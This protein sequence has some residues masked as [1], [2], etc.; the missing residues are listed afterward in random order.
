MK[1]C[2]ST[3]GCH[4]LV[5]DRI[6]DLANKYGIE[7]IEV[8]GINN[9]LDNEKIDDFKLHNAQLTMEKFKSHNVDLYSLGTSCSFHDPNTRKQ[10]IEKGF[11]E[12]HIANSLNVTNIRVFGN[13]ILDS[14]EIS[15]NLV[16]DGLK[17]MCEYALPYD[18]TVLL[19]VH[20]D[21]NSIDTLTPIVNSLKEYTNFGLIW[22]IYHTHSTHKND[23]DKFYDTFKGYIK[24]IHIKDSIGNK[25]VLPGDGEIEFTKIVNYVLN[26]GYDGYFSLEWERKWNPEL[27][28]LE[29]A[30]NKYVD[31]LKSCGEPK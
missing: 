9:E 8:R 3:L 19:E 30:L 2:F 7:A 23:W 28:S 25:L 29:E 4:D 18:V 21:F 14:K 31:I 17:T 11:R 24:H 1:L 15:T 10:K 26:K 12:I 20:G 6:L 27:P 16:I 22:D 5:L 13:N